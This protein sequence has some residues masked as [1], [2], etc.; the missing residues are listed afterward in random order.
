MSTMWPPSL[1]RRVVVWLVGLVAVVLGTYA[2][3]VLMFLR[4]SLRG[5]LDAQLYQD[6][7]LVEQLLTRRPDGNVA[8][9]FPPHEDADVQR[10]IEVWD[11]SRVV[12]RED[13]VG[14]ATAW[15]GPPGR[16]TGYVYASQPPVSGAVWRSVAGVHAV[17]GGDVTIRVARPETSVR[18]EIRQL[19][20]VLAVAWPLALTLAGLGGSLV[21]RRALSPLD[22]MA[23]RARTISADRLDERFVVHNPDD[24]LGKLAGA[25]NE[26]FARLD[27]AFGRLKRF[28]ADASHELRLHSRQ[29]VQ[30][31][32]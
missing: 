14:V 4:G 26:G 12:L 21:V 2:V 17:E 32:R 25:F 3:G 24:E 6:F 30:L 15:P 31:A 10:T 7:E 1:R 27:D 23:K 5:A 11:G 16:V 8:W 29:F 19:A 20:V 13:R 28:T 18:D 9:K 22:D